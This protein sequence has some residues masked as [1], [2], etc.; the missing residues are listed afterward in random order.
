MVALE[1]HVTAGKREH[2]HTRIVELLFAPPKAD[3]FDITSHPISPHHTTHRHIGGEARMRALT[4]LD[5]VELVVA[6]APVPNITHFDRD[7]VRAARD[8]M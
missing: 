3:L 6:P 7:K 1:L 5:A 4:L 8:V 2:T